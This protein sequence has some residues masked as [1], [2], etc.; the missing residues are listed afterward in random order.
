MCNRARNRAE[1]EAE[2]WFGDGLLTER[3]RDNRFNLLEMVPRGRAY[4]VRGENGRRGVDVMS[5]GVLGGAAAWPMT[6]LADES[7]LRLQGE[8]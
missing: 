7:V 5:W 4:V 3:P 8:V 6:K 1:P 2:T